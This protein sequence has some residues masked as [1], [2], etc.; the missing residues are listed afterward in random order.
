MKVPKGVQAMPEVYGAILLHRV[1]ETN[2]GR[3][4]KME[5]PFK[6]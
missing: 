5:S 1:V 6:S 2:E 4:L 3:S